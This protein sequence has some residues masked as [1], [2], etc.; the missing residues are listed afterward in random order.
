MKLDRDALEKAIRLAMI[1]DRHPCRRKLAQLAALDEGDGARV[2]QLP[3]LIARL[4]RSQQQVAMRQQPLAFNYPD[5]P[6]VDK[7][8]DILSALKQHQVVVIAGETGSGKT[9]QLPKL[10]LDAGL[11]VHGVI[12]HTQPRRLAARA[13]AQRLSEELNVELGR[14]V[15]CQIRFTDQSDDSTR[16]KVMTDGILL[17]QIQRDPYLNEYDA[18]IIDEAHERSLNI[19]FLLG[20]LKQLLPKRRDLT[21]I[22]TSATIDVERF[23]K[24]FDDAPIISVSGR[25]YPVELLYQPLLRQGE[26]DD[27]LSMYEGIEQALETCAKL[28]RKKGNHGDVL[29]FLSGERDIRACAEHLRKTLTQPHE[30]LPLYAR[31]S[32]ADQQKIFKPR[33]TRR[34][35]L[36]TN[37]AETSL[38]VPGI[39]YVIDTGLARI[40]RYSYKSKVQRLPIEQISQASA[41]QRA[42]RCG[43][44]ELG[45]CIR[46]YDE[47]DYLAQREFT[48]P[49]IQR[50]NLAAVILQMLNLRLGRIDQF[51]FLDAPDTRYIKDG[52]KLLQ[53]LG[54]V[55]QQE[56]LT[57]I[58]KQMAK[59]PLDPRIARI[60][61]SAGASGALNEV[62][63]IASALSVQDPRE[64]PAEKKQAADMQHKQWAHDDSDFMSWLNLWQAYE[65]QRQALTQNQ[66]RKWCKKH[67]LSYLRLREWRDVHH[68]LVVQCKSMTLSFNEQP[69]SYEVIHRV[70]IEGFITHVAM[71]SEQGEYLGT[72]NR[73][74]RI[75]PASSQYKKQPKWILAGELA[76]TSQLFARSVA[77]IEP[78]WVEE[79]AKGLLKY[80]YFEPHWQQKRG[81]AMAFE[82]STLYGLIINPKKRVNYAITHPKEARELLILHGLVEQKMNTKADFYH[83]NNALLQQV[84]EVEEKSRRRDLV[85]DDNVLANAYSQR[86]PDD[87][88]SVAHLERWYKRLDDNAKKALL[89][90]REF[91]LNEAAGDVKDDDFPTELLWQGLAFPLSYSFAPGSVDDGVTLTVPVAMLDQVPSAQTEWLVPGLVENKVVAL[92]KGLPKSVRKS[93]IPAPDHAQLFLQQ[94]RPSQ[95][96]LYA[97]FLQFINQKAHPKL[98]IDAILDIE[99]PEHLRMNIVVLDHADVVGQ[100]R[101]LNAL[102]AT[103]KGDGREQVSQV[104]CDEFQRS[105]ITQWDFGDLP[106]QTQTHVHGLPVRAFVCL[107][108]Q[109]NRISLTVETSSLAAQTQHRQGVVALLRKGFSAQE[110]ALKKLVQTT[111][112]AHWLKAKGLDDQKSLIDDIVHA[113]IAHV[114][115]PSDESLPYSESE[116]AA[117]RERRGELMT[118]GERLIPAFARWIELRHQVLKNMQGAI[119]LDK[120]MAF[121]DIKQHLDYLCAKGFIARTPWVWLQRYERYLNAMLLRLDKLQ[122]NLARDRQCTLEFNAIAEP[123]YELVKD[124]PLAQYDEWESFNWLLQE[125]R[126]GLF[127]QELGT[128]EP[129]SMKRMKKLWES[130][131]KQ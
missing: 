89:F 1:K 118:F 127:A 8:E 124:Q 123:F 69:A 119:S 27:D 35:V 18:I 22:I 16:V 37:V 11:G 76:E 33:N 55:N 120:A 38:T 25:T 64:R 103:L 74:L 78:H 91:L 83:A 61:L 2:K 19:D 26:D 79:V 82:Q 34:V 17:A 128:K 122:G 95:G 129:V 126:V 63:I 97:Q 20:Y 112:G 6:V 62:L 30:V 66:L 24:H 94:H 100:G 75:F 116:F 57:H 125:W 46:L 51:P 101:D 106:Q 105:D 14:E 48:E 104:T 131:P 29:V 107:S 15:G 72:R 23:S 85:V 5:L 77:K 52:I 96:G 21:L 65:E 13:V 28:D 87:I 39:R 99:L 86:L 109:G 93:F 130:L 84:T 12:G 10:C 58:G 4:E 73:K 41:N 59:V 71:K 90:T 108:A 9:T 102:K 115:L 47:A 80:Q 121:S 7:K 111:V 40:S 45:V 50:T 36:S 49:E 110:Q 31:L 44:T 68:Q 43:R 32:G 53:E 113:V 60:V 88:V 42:G 117:A 92:I 3:A 98:A 67:F 54:G 70:L 56:T 114:C 81:Q